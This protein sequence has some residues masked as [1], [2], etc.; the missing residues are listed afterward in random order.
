MSKTCYLRLYLISFLPDR[1]AAPSKGYQRLAPR[2]STKNWF[3]HFANPSFNF[4]ESK[5]AKFVLILRPK[6]TLD[7]TRLDTENTSK[8]ERTPGVLMIDLC[9]DQIWFSSV[10]SSVRLETRC[11]CGAMKDRRISVESSITEI[12]IQIY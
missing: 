7:R 11:E 1:A 6:S 8:I 5:S 12:Q 2:L 9:P 4:T 3:S 10:H